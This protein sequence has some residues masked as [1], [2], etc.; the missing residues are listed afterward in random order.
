MNQNNKIQPHFWN[1]NL[2]IERLSKLEKWKDQERER[3][4]KHSQY[5][6]RLLSEI[7]LLETW[8][9]NG[10]AAAEKLYETTKKARDKAKPTTAEYNQEG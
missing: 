5:Y 7:H 6:R 9:H 8:L 1:K 3:G 10:P 4:Q 2:V